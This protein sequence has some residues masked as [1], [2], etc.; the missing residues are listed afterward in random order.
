MAS[1][2]ARWTLIDANIPVYRLPYAILDTAQTLMERRQTRYL[3]SHA[4][5]AEQMWRVYGFSQLPAL[6]TTSNGRP[7]FSDPY[8]PDFSIAY[9]GNIVG[10]LLAEEQGKAGLDMEIVRSYSRHTR[11]QQSHKFSSGETAW[12]KAQSDP[13]EAAIQLRALRQS[14]LKL[15]RVKTLENSELQLHP[16]SGRLRLLTSDN[17]E[18]ISDVEPLIIWACAL[19]AGDG[20]LHL[21]EFNG[22]ESWKQLKEIQISARN[23]EPQMLHLT[24]L[25]K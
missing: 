23:M 19:S 21:W 13:N 10:V 2:F 17:I 24:N 3:A 25:Y 20:L 12:I 7:C 18:I 14:V 1:H 6:A 4:L 15:T 22:L 9:A 11:E 5:L 8:L 16:A